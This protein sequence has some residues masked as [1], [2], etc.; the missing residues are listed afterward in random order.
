MA[1]GFGLS[2]KGKH[3]SAGEE[4]QDIDWDNLPV[5]QKNGWGMQPSKAPTPPR[6]TEE[7]W[8]DSQLVSDEGSQLPT[9]DGQSRSARASDFDEDQDA[10]SE[11]GGAQ[12]KTN[13]KKVDDPTGGVKVKKAPLPR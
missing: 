11:V 3:N 7:E 9:N 4:V 5:Q 1:S 12:M 2:N 8:L 10:G 13:K 6:A